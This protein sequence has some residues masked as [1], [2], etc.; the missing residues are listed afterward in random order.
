VHTSTEEQ[1]HAG[2]GTG[3]ACTSAKKQ[4][5][6]CT[7]TARGEGRE[8]LSTAG[9]WPWLARPLLPLPELHHACTS[10]LAW[11]FVWLL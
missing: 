3:S 7:P 2:A 9:G 1:A 8:S 6:V 10:G 5:E 4:R 11:V